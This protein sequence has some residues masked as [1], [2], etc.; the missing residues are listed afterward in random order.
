MTLYRRS[1]ADLTRAALVA[2][3]DTAARVCEHALN[4]LDARVCRASNDLSE[5]D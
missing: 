4:H 5:E 1:L 2:A 3:V